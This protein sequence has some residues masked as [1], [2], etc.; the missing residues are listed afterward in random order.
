MG[1]RGVGKKTFRY[2]RGK[3]RAA[4]GNGGY[5]YSNVGFTAGQQNTLDKVVYTLLA[6]VMALFSLFCTV[7]FIL[8]F[9]IQMENG[10]SG[11][12][13]VLYILTIVFS[14]LAHRAHNKFKV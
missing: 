11:I 1:G 2:N 5:G 9:K 4:R 14:C 7:L 6:V 13:V 3:K 12:L 8:E 10:S